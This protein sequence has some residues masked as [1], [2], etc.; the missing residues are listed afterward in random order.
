MVEFHPVL[1]MMDDDYQ[2][3][4]Y[5]YFNRSPFHEI[6]TTSYTDGEGH[7][8]TEGYCWNHSLA[9]ILQFLI[10]NEVEITDF[11]EYDHSP[12]DCFP[13]MVR[14]GKGYQLKAFGENVPLIFSLV[15]RKK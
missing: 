11:Q 1:G 4:A 3:I 5:S 15:G 10:K 13:N 6:H 7:T 14:G 2:K 9:D 12:Y 8:P